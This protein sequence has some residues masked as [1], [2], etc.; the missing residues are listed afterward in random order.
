MSDPASKGNPRVTV[1]FER[2][3][4]LLYR[5]KQLE[6]IRDLRRRLDIVIEEMA[7]FLNYISDSAEVYK[8]IQA[9]NKG[10]SNIKIRETDDGFKIQLLIDD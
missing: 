5:E 9:F 6:D 2:Y 3:K 7:V 4:E 1:D 8:K 10:S